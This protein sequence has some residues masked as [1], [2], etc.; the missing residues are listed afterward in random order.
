M[1]GEH[2]LA[3][4]HAEKAVSLNPNA[5]H[6]MMFVAETKACLGEIDTAC[7]LIEKAMQNDPYSAPAFRETKVD[8]YYLAGRYQEVADQLVGWPNPQPHTRLAVAAAL[9]QLGREAEVRTE[10]QRVNDEA[11]EGWDILKAVHAYQNMC[12]MPEDAERWLY[13]FRK[14]GLDV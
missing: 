3:A 7:A 14:A 12:V 6:V 13:G 10:L 9:A 4:Y 2:A 11:P 8:I 5:F 1:V